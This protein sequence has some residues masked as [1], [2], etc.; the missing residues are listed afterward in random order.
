MQLRT[1][2]LVVGAGVS[3]LAFADSLVQHDPEAELVIVDRRSGPGGHWTDVYPFVRLHSPS[4][5]YGV[6]SVRLGEDRIDTEG[7]NAGLYERATAAEL[8]E[9]FAEVVARLTATG[10]VQVLLGHEH[11]G[12]AAGGPSVRDLATGETHEVVVR[13]R[14]V[15]ARYLEVAVPATHTPSFE[16]ADDARFVPVHLLG[17]AAE[18]AS[19]Y[20]VLGSGKTAVDAVLWLL[21]HGVDPERIRWVRPR[22]AWFHDR[23]TFQPLDLVIDSMAGFAADAEIGAKADDATSLLGALEEAGRLIRLDPSTPASMYRGAML[24]PYELER[25]RT[26]TDVVRLGR[27]RRLERDRLVLDDGELPTGD[28]LHVDCT[29]QGLRDMPPV[30]IFAPGRIVLQQVRHKTPPYNAALLGYVE[31]MR[32]DD[33]TR[34]RLCPPNHYTRDVR[35]WARTV[36]R[37][38]R[39]EGSWQSDPDLQA[40]ASGTRLNL[41]G[42]VPQHLASERAQAAL[43]RYVTYVGDAV[44]NLERIAAEGQVS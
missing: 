26:I 41:V 23:T 6:D 27:A 15:D 16:I 28:A 4:A 34:N 21:E 37:T 24:S 8:Q 12:E 29:A 42:A 38:W 32:D 2:Y 7:T 22:D 9:Y 35:D 31:A 44:V 36:A 30:P 43:T 3:G 33:E 11:V 17:E 39:T 13:R 19:S 40:W 14:L 18:S 25:V 1:D 10:R 20:T 5:F